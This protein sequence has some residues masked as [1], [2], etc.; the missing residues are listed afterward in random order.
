V[1]KLLPWA[2]GIARGVRADYGFRIGSTEEEELEGVAIVALVELTQRYY[3]TRLPSGGRVMDAFKGWAAVEVRSRCRRA[4]VQL[5][6]GGTVR[7]TSDADVRKMQIETLPLTADGSE[8][9]LAWPEREEDDE[10]EEKVEC[11]H[12]PHLVVIPKKACHDDGSA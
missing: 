12:E 11:R 8:V 7:T 5:R 4:A 3:E 2:K 10:P 6:T 9:S 1:E